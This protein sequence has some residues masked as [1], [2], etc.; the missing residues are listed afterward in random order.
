MAKVWVLHTGTKGTGAEMVPLDKTLSKP[1]AASEPIL[2]PGEPT[3]QPTEQP[4]QREPLRFKVVDV[5]TNRVLADGADARATVDLMKP[6]RSPVDVR[7]YAWRP[8]AQKWRLVSFREQR[9][10]WE[11]SRAPKRESGPPGGAAQTGVATSEN[12]SRQR[13]TARRS[14][15]AGRD[16]RSRR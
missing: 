11:A 3:A 8:A 1:A 15:A 7:I 14:P 16:R 5:M 10:L 2:P 13:A 9:A 4:E 12:L 6:V